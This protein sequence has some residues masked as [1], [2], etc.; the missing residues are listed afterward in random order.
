MTRTTKSFGAALILTLLSVSCDIS[1]RVSKLEKQA[2][3]MQSDKDRMTDYDLQ[4]KCSKDA[5]AWFNENWS[6]DKDTILLDFMNHYNKKQNKCF[7][8]VERH[9]NSNLAAPGGTSW[10]NDMSLW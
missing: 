10:T 4:A 3:G 5:K 9:Y 1:D 2:K 6:S 7:I 8:L